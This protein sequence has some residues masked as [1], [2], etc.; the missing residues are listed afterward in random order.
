MPLPSKLQDDVISELLSIG[1]HPE[2]EVLTKS[3]YRLDALVEVHGKKIGIEVDGPS[4]FVGRKPT[5]STLLKRRQVNTL[6]EILLIS[7]PYWE[8][9]KFGKDGGKKQQYL[10]LA[11]GLE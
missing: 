7:V 4:H 9:N 1:L 10:R 6:D 5:G 11:L 3:G 2:E 8:W